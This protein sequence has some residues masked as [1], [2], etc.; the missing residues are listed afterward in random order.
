[1]NYNSNATVHIITNS[2]RDI[3]LNPK[4]CHIKTDC[5]MVFGSVY[6]STG[7]HPD[8]AKVQAI[9]DLTPPTNAAQ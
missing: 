5:I 4:K 1:M 3:V 7:I 6:S 9:H 2:E 8:P